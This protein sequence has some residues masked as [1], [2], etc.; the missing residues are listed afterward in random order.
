[1]S[2]ITFEA[3]TQ[4]ADHLVEQGERPTLAKV[5]TLLGGGSYTTISPL[6]KQWRDS[7]AVEAATAPITDPAPEEITSEFEAMFS[8]VWQTAMGLAN[9]RL[10]AEREALEQTRLALEAER[11]EAAELAD[12]VNADLEKVTGE[13]D[14]VQQALEAVKTQ[15]AES[16]QQAQQQAQ[17]LTE[18]AQAIKDAQAATVAAQ[19]RGDEL[20]GLLDDERAARAKIEAQAATLHEKTEAQTGTIATLQAK[21]EGATA[22][23]VDLQSKLAKRDTDLASANAR[24]E[25]CNA[26]LEA[27]AR[28]IEKAEQE[29]EKARKTAADASKEAAHLQGRVVELEKQ[30]AKATEAQ[31]TNAQT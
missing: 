19:A 20:R 31:A 12:L 22:T 24:V 10:A 5:R 26:R 15:L 4:A 8:R 23:A 3:V 2:T 28:D 21:L 25:A 30:L 16:Q 13:R 14:A 11:D 18:Q 6:L 27:A 29:Q 7:Q 9:A 1:M 17:Q